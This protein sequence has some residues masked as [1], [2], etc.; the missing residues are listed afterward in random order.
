VS[1]PKETPRRVVRQLKKARADIA[2]MLI[3]D[4]LGEPTPSLAE[5][6]R[7]CARYV[8]AAKKAGW[9]P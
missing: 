7:A 3:H 1:K 2:R 4:A 9:T 8:A 6:A 5:F